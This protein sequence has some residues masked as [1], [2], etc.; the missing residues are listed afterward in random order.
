MARVK[1]IA[2]NGRFLTQ[3]VTG[4]QR[5][6]REFIREM[7]ILLRE[8]CLPRLK[9]E[10]LVPGGTPSLAELD[11]VTVRSVGRHHGHFWEQAEL[12]TSLAGVDLLFCPGNLAPL[13]TL[14]AGRVPVVTTV[15]DASYRQFPRA[16]SRAFRLWYNF[17]TPIIFSR[18]AALLTVSETERITLLSLYPRSSERLFAVPNGGLPRNIKGGGP[19]P[20]GVAS[21]Y[22][23][24]AGSLSQRKNFQGVMAAASHIH[25]DRL[26][27]FVFSGGRDRSFT[28]AEALDHGSGLLFLGQVN[29]LERLAA[30]YRNAACFVFPSFYESS[31]L[32]PIEAMAM[33]CPVVASDIAALRER[34]GDAAL[35]CDPFDSR[36]I[37]AAILR[38]C[39]EPLLRQT[40]V[41]K[42]LKR[43]ERFSWRHCV[44]QTLP[45]LY[46]AANRNRMSLREAEAAIA[47]AFGPALI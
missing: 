37:A 31:G 20:D 42:G 41:E 12:P 5:Y 40:L 34:C 15:H 36:A 28:P 23:L 3:P 24:Y 7:D 35:Y 45:V 46:R 2:I 33:G 18:S 6:G 27:N 19:L 11:Q 17:A 29:D 32:P 16:Y 4:V 22:V 21:P 8:Q 1:T 38:I 30:L 9:V 10:L 14:L 26:L 39:D 47:E 43:A 44:R 25:A 13:E